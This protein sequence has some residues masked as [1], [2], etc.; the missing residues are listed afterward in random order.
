MIIRFLSPRSTS[1]VVFLSQVPGYERFNL[2]EA[3]NGVHPSFVNVAGDARHI[4]KT[5]FSIC[6]SGMY[7]I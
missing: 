2:L 3:F 4:N 7:L 1:S 5:G 6:K